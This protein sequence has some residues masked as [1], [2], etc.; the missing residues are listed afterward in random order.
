MRVQEPIFKPVVCDGGI[1]A[2]AFSNE[3]CTVFSISIQSA[4][5]LH[6]CRTLGLWQAYGRMWLRVLRLRVSYSTSILM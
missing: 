3:T 2:V 6:T 4:S 1:R 5:C